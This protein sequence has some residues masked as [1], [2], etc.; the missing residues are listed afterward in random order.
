L[1]DAP[2]YGGAWNVYPFHKSGIVTIAGI[3]QGLFVVQPKPEPNP[4]P[5]PTPPGSAILSS[6]EP[7]TTFDKPRV[8]LTWEAEPCAS[9]YTVILQEKTASGKQLRERVDVTKTKYKTL[10]L[11]PGK[12]YLW[13]V[14]A[15]NAWG[16]H[17]SKARRFSVQ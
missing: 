8:R 15:C 3:E 14:L 1:D 5:C 9:T 4:P 16:C 11:E 12:L 13:K 17:K 6:P 2:E 7:N 10:P